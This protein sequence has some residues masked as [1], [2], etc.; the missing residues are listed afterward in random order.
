MFEC[1]PH[2]MIQAD[3]ELR[4]NLVLLGIRLVAIPTFRLGFQLRGRCF[5]LIVMKIV[6]TPTSGI[7]VALAILDRHIG[8]VQFSGK[9][10]SAG[11]LSSRAVRKLSRDRELQLLE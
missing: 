8:T 10:S 11:G 9:V 6:V 3:V 7:G 5:R 4:P 1:R 2:S